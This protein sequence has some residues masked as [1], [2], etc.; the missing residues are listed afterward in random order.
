METLHEICQAGLF[1]AFIRTT[2][3]SETAAA[4]ARGK[5][6]AKLMYALE[7]KHIQALVFTL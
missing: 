3:Q 1:C 2:R 5:S 7:E 6:K 4:E